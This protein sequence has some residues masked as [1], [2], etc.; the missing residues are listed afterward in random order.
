MG[1]DAKAGPVKGHW[2]GWTG[3]INWIVPESLMERLGRVADERA[4]TRSEYG[5]RALMA[6]IERDERID[7]KRRKEEGR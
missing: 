3:R 6:A 5:R 7:A 4:M 1:K 2:K